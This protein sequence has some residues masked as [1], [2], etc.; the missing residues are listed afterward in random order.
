MKI[1]ILSMQRVPNFGSLLQSYAL[2]HMLEAL[3]HSVDFI[4]IEPNDADND[5]LDGYRN[6]FSREGEPQGRLAA[7]IAKID[8]YALNRIRIKILSNLQNKQ[9]EAFRTSKLGMHDGTNEG[10]YD[11]CVIGS[12]EVFNCLSGA[13]WGFT[14]QLF[15]NV[16]QAKRVITYAASCGATTYEK[17]PAAAAARIRDVFNRVAGFSVRD[18]NT[19]RFVSELS[20]K[21]VLEHMDPVVVANFDREID[22]A[23]LP[24][25]LP[26][27]YCVVYSY[28][29]RICDENDIS[30]IKAFCRAHDMKIIAVGAPQMW[31]KDYRVLNPFE[32]LKVF[33]N[34]AF[35]ITDTFHGTIFS[36]K[37]S[38]RFAVMTRSSNENKLLDLIGRLG[39]EKHLIVS[40]KQLDTVYPFENKTEQILVLA[41][42][43]RKRSMQY[44]NDNLQGTMV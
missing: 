21:Q 19:F 23:M 40:T 33:Q 34:A 44:L 11:Y 3:G 13:P 14:S 39:V 5:L 22:E 24:K 38:K 8:K 42:A 12:D 9:F 25:N 28:Y 29:N 32:M 26:E 10:Q 15:G 43:E 2:K 1:C 37:Y 16:R 17:V 4:D 31:I 41:E 27:R 36:A 30:N 35:V 18:K 7:K 6:C 20:D